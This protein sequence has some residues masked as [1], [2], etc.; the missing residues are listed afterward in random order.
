MAQ[1]ELTWV[2]GSAPK[3]FTYLKMVTHPC[4]NRVQRRVT[5]LIAT[6][7]LTCVKHGKQASL[8]IVVFLLYIDG[9]CAFAA[10]VS[11]ASRQ[12][13]LCYGETCS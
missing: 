12:V 5:T 11:S 13:L 3:W 4:T 6:N 1:A 10:A 8:T 9:I 2:A 7:R